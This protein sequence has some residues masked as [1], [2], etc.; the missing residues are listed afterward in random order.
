[1]P[2]INRVRIINFSYNNN[3]RNIVDETFDYYQGE[4]ALLS[5]Q[6]GGGKSVLV[7]VMLQP[8]IPKV[9]LM[10]RRIEDF[11][12]G[13]KTPSYIM[14][15][16]KLEGG[17]GYLLTGIGLANRESRIRE[18]DDSSNQVKYFTFMSHYRSSN[19]FDIEN[20][21]LIRKSSSRIYVEEFNDARK[22]IKAKE[23]DR[24]FNVRLYTQDDED[25]KRYRADLQSFNIFQDEWESI[26]LKINE[27]EGGVIEIFEKCRTSQQLMNEWILKSVEKVVNKDDGDHQKLELM[28]ENLVEEM[29]KNEQLDRKSVV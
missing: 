1:M 27:S 20:I 23:E 24:E 26:V 11:F 22:L 4:N 15:E 29:I 14:I 28:L 3:N 16:W 19:L 12:K 13:R 6:N 5:L 18:Q 2:Q 7:Q 10:R 8:I 9:K 21:P 17:G 25:R